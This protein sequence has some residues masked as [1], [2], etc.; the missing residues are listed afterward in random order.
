M[1]QHPRCSQPSE[2]RMTRPADASLTYQG[3]PCRRG[4]GMTRYQTSNACVVCTKIQAL[5]SKRRKAARIKA[6][7]EAQNAL[8]HAI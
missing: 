7:R 8:A 4:H 6:A 5:A 3:R 2:N 1:G